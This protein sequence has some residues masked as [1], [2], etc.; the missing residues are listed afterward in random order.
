[1]RTSIATIDR[2]RSQLTTRI[3]G[4]RSP[5]A[6][7]V[8][9]LAVGVSAAVYNWWFRSVP[10]GLV[11]DFSQLWT[12]ARAWA[13]HGVDPYTI[14]WIGLGHLLLYPFPAVLVASPLALLPMH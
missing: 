13:L 10:Q 12:D 1:M 3:G 8:F 5:L 7:I 11:S 2:L 9:S 14:R 6:G 4:E